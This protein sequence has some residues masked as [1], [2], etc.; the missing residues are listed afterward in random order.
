MLG[1]RHSSNLSAYR[2]TIPAWRAAH[3]NAS[4]SETIMVG[5]NVRKLNFANSPLAKLAKASLK[6]QP[7]EF[8]SAF[9]HFNSDQVQVDICAKHNEIFV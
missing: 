2:L 1:T 8:E 4:I 3:I 6:T 5:F 7:V 9:I